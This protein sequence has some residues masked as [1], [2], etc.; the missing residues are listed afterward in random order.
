MATYVIMPRQGQS[1]E[2]CIIAK[3]HKK[4]GDSVAIG[5][6]LFSYE[7]D[8]AS[9][10]EEAKVEGVVLEIFHEEGDDVPCLSNVCA[11]GQPGEA[12]E[13]A[14]QDAQADTKPEEKAVEVNKEI[15]AA[16][17][18]VAADVQGFDTENVKISPRAKSAADRTGVD[19]AKVVPTGPYGRIIEKDILEAREKGYLLTAAAKAALAGGDASSV[20]AGSGIGGRITTADL[21]RTAA[22]AVESAAAAVQQPVQSETEVVKIPN[23]RKV[24]AKAMQNSISSTCQ[25][26]LNSSFDATEIMEFRKKLKTGKEKLGL[27]NITIND[28]ILFAVSRTLTEFRDLNA[29]M[30]DDTMIYYKNVNLGVAVDTERGLMVPNIFNANHKSLSEISA[31]V[32]TL[33]KD[34][35]SGKISP[36]VL[37]NGSFTVTNLGTLDVESFTPVLNAPQTGILGVN[38]IIQRAKE[39]DGEIVFYPAMGLSLT[40]DHKALDGAPAAKFLQAL[41]RNLENFTCL[42]IK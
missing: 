25:L 5:D 2:S 33:V 13:N 10:D 3:W 21:G 20:A 19:I 6:L 7:T 17:E 11:I 1:V 14:A 16:P 12:V 37:K 28:M 32:K 9:F 35:Q 31:E 39:I 22:P 38:N 27:E 4:K 36:D 18:A 24:I 40:F 41:K 8:K 30:V 34:C 42:L 26:T 15:S 23:I 29:N